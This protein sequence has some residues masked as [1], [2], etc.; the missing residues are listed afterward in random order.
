MAQN[1]YTLDLYSQLSIKLFL[2]E[3][4]YL[5]GMEKPLK[6]Y[7]VDAENIG[8]SMLDELNI[9]ILD[10]VFVFTNSES[11]KSACSNALL[12]CVSG[13]PSGPNQADFYIIAHLSN[14]L[15]HLSKAEKKAIE[16]NLCSK[17]QNLWK[18]FEFQCSQA[19]VKSSA[20][21]I[22]L[23]SESN[24]VVLAID[25]SIEAKILKLM[26]KPIT[27]LEIQQKLKITQSEFTTSF[28]QLIK[29]GKIKRQES[30][31]KHWFRVNGS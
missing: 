7:Y 13:Y 18:A 11:L 12:T 25:T 21:Y 17:D 14:V 28:N 27:S 6:I 4:V 31:R 1:I 10:R 19:G 30:S 24:N 3:V 15:S 20:P 9:S 26:S 5:P 23:Q 16:F 29:S 8:L 22:T 2:S